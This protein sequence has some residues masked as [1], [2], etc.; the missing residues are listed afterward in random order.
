MQQMKTQITHENM[1]DW[2]PNT[3][4]VSRWMA[5]TY[6]DQ[7]IL[8]LKNDGHTVETLHDELVEEKIELLQDLLD[9]AV[10]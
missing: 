10:K 3:F 9:E 1:H 7:L 4:F 6:A 5:G 8:A 2:M